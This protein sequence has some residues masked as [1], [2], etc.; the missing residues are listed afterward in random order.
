MWPCFLPGSASASAAACWCPGTAS[1]HH[2][3]LL[4]TVDAGQAHWG[5]ASA[6]ASAVHTF[7]RLVPFAG[8]VSDAAWPA[9]SLCS[10][11]D[12][13]LCS[14]SG[15]FGGYTAFPLGAT[16]PAPKLQQRVA[17]YRGSAACLEDT[18]SAKST[19]AWYFRQLISADSLYQPVHRSVHPLSVSAAVSDR[20]L[21]CA[22]YRSAKAESGK[23]TWSHGGHMGPTTRL[24]WYVRPSQLAVC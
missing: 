16:F 8:A 24:W 4:S 21:R 7:G 23:D 14:P 22:V 3:L 15:I 9:G 17:D 1:A 12:R 2:T 10:P 6:G 5:V 18:V 19:K 13:A 20:C 11:F